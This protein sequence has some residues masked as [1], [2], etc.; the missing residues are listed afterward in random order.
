MIDMINQHIIPSMTRAAVKGYST[1]DLEA[2]V[3]TL[4]AV[5]D[6]YSDTVTH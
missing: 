2:A 1:A 5:R 3:K 4:Q 6:T